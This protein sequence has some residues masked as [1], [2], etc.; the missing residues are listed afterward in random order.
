M[1]C[2]I[3]KERCFECRNGAALIAITAVGAFSVYGIMGRKGDKA[4]AQI[5]I[6]FCRQEVKVKTYIITGANSGLGFETAKR[7]AKC[8]GTWYLYMS[9]FARY[10]H[11]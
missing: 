7:I 10:S 11:S 1:S 6:S 2:R 4:E 8:K 5:G 3:T 9:S